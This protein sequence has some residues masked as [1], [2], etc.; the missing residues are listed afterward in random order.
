[1]MIDGEVTQYKHAVHILYPCTHRPWV[2]LYTAR[3]GTD[4]EAAPV[5]QNDDRWREVTQYTHAVYCVYTCT[6]AWGHTVH[7]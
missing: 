1:M 6:Q 3:Q 5:V 7:S 2:T 4:H